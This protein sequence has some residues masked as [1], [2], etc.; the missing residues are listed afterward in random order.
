MGERGGDPA[1]EARAIIHA[2]DHGVEL[3]DTA[4]MYASG[5][6]E[7]VI[8]LALRESPAKPFVV[9]KVYPHNAS[10]QG[11]VEACENSLRRMEI[12]CIDLCLLHW[13]GPTPFE[14]TIKGFES[15]MQAGK[16]GAWG[17]SNFD[18]EDMAEL[19]DAPGGNGCQTNQVLYNLTRRWPEDALSPALAAKQTPLMAYAPMEQGRLGEEAALTRIAADAGLDPMELALAW[20]IAQPNVFAVPK[21]ARPARI[22]GFLRAAELQ[23]HPDVLSALDAAFPAPSAGA[24]LEML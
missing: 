8:G 22:D 1:A 3:L 10:R 21:S 13:R 9:S 7:E 5:G 12:D 19:W 4:E 24:E 17:V 6:A 2:L 20:V 16:I 15:L 14:E 23:L 11:V 18:A